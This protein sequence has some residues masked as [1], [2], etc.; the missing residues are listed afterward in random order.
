MNNGKNPLKLKGKG[1]R[2]LLNIRWSRLN[3]KNKRKNLKKLRGSLSF[4]EE[5]N[6]L[7]FLRKPKLPIKHFNTIGL[8]KLIHQVILSQLKQSVLIVYRLELILIL[9]L[10]QIINKVKA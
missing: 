2:C 10:F 9:Y 8:Y 1:E 6:L 4:I 3:F 5:D 7:K